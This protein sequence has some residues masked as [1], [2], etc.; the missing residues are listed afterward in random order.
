M[1]R[2]LSLV[3]EVIA[4]FRISKT[5]LEYLK[6]ELRGSRDPEKAEIA[7]FLRF[8]LMQ[9]FCY[10]FTKKHRHK[11]V[12]ARFDSA[13]GFPYVVHNGKDVFPQ[14]LTAQMGQE[15]LSR[16]FE[17]TRHRFAASL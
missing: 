11:E 4:R 3:K 6:E 16:H 9:A 5:V 12:E 15:I 7:K 17:R 1:K 14:R 13:S 10:D 2:I 8:N